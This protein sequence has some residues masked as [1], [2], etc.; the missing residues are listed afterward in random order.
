MFY[1]KRKGKKVKERKK[2]TNKDRN[3]TKGKEKNRI[4][5]GYTAPKEYVCTLVLK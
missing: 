5:Q 1:N 2:Q 4:V 3:K